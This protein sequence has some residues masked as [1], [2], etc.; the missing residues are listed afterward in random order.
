MF[1]SLSI[2]LYFNHLASALRIYNSGFMLLLD[3]ACLRC[4][5]SV[6]LVSGPM[7]PLVS[8]KM[9]PPISQLRKPEPRFFVMQS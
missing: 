1:V 6:S 9:V 5:V 2:E 7:T 8:V 4:K 3:V